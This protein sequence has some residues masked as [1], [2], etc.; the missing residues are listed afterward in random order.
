MLTPAW[1][2][3]KPHVLQSRLWR[4]D[5]RFVAVAAGRG[6]GKTELARRRLVRFL[7]IK[8]PWSTPLYFYAGPTYGQAKRVAWRAL[9]DLVP[10][11]WVQSISES[12]MVIRTIFGSEL[13]VVGM[14]KPQRIEGVQWD[15]GVIDECSDQKPKVFDLT[16]RPALSHREGWCWRI[17]VPKRHGV[18]ALE[19][20]SCFERD[21]GWDCY[22]WPSADILEPD[23]IEFARQM[24]DA[25]DFAEQYE[26]SWV[27]SGGMAFHAFDPDKH[28]RPV[29]YDETKPIIV[30]S[31]FNVDPMAWVLCHQ[32]EGN[33][34][35]I[36]DEI[37]L[38]DTNTRKT[39]DI[40]YARYP[41]H[42][43]GW[44]FLGDATGRAR[45]TAA[46][47]SDYVIIKQ[48]ERFQGNIRYPKANPM[49]KDRLASCNALM[50]HDRLHIDARCTN[51]ILDLEFRSLDETG[52]P[53]D[54]GDQ[55]HITDALG[56]V[57]HT[58]YPVLYVRSGDISLSLA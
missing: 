24:L 8:K 15:G 7:P 29:A 51:L 39:L 49:I 52:N 33:G 43:G 17:G 22:N 5:K 11:N 2:T 6:S 18:G 10:K 14:D 58:M 13:H 35:D 4:T 36:F 50:C 27:K 32:G 12:D 28:I 9:K 56:Y 23:E 19:F 45:K 20:R 3:L 41:E 48:D 53:D 40:L 30:G 1:T 57:I 55:G 44:H 26:A 31:D 42:Q 47:I 37:W 46:T 54:A 25:K 16:V 21:S 38:R 34:L